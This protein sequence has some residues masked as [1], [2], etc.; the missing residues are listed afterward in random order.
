MNQYPTL[1]T[2][3]WLRSQIYTRTQHNSKHI[4]Y[5]LLA[6]SNSGTPI[7]SLSL[8]SNCSTETISNTRGQI[9]LNPVRLCPI[10]VPIFFRSS[11]NGL[12]FERLIMAKSHNSTWINFEERQKESQWPTWFNCKFLK[13]ILRQFK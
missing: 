13:L 5:F 10:T 8:K 11:L 7:L 9:L 12:R 6:T 1:C 2:I 4:H 3:I